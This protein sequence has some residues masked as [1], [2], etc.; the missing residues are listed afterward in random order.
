VDLC[1]ELGWCRPQPPFDT[2]IDFGLCKPDYVEVVLHPKHG[3]ELVVIDAKVGKLMQGGCG[4]HMTLVGVLDVLLFRDVV[5]SQA[6]GHVHLKHQVQVA[7]YCLLMQRWG[8]AVSRTGGIWRPGQSSPE[9][10]DTTKL[11]AMLW[12]RRYVGD[13]WLVK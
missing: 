1:R 6:S 10:F 13:E 12:V 9:T 8:L 3:R 5:A 11:M 2:V 7:L 4:A